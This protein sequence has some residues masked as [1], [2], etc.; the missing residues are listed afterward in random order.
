MVERNVDTVTYVTT[1]RNG[2]KMF[3]SSKIGAKISH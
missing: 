1:I 2:F 3:L